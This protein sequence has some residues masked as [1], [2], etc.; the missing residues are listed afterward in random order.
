MVEPAFPSFWNTNPDYSIQAGS[1]AYGALATSGNS[2][3]F[4]EDNEATSEARRSVLFSGFGADGTTA[5]ASFLIR[6]DSDP[7]VGLM[8]FGVENM[9]VGKIFGGSPDFYAVGEGG[10]IEYSTVPIVQ[11]QTA[12][13][14]IVFQFNP[15][16]GGQDTATVF[17]D[18]TPGLAT[19][20]VSGLVWTE[21]FATAIDF[22]TMDGGNGQAYSFDEIRIGGTYADVTPLTVSAVPEPSSIWLSVAG[23]ACLLWRTR[24]LHGYRC[25]RDK[26]R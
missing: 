19:P 15:D 20:D 18:P 9:E 21:D 10:D 4:N 16:S 25:A 24:F 8:E 17:F 7:T 1:L 11:G 2:A 14:S 6:P 12:F 22:L 5:W 26:S 23:L 13:V 3:A